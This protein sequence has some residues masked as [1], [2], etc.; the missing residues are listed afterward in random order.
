MKRSWSLRA[1]LSLLLALTLLTGVM[2]ALADGINIIGTVTVTNSSYVN[3]RTGGA[4]TYPVVATVLPGSIYPCIGTAPTGW[5]EILL[6]NGQTGFVSNNLTSFAPGGTGQLPGGQDTGAI[7]KTISVTYRTEAGATLATDYVT[8]LYGV[9]IVPAN[10]GKVPAGYT[11]VSTRRVTVNVDRYG[12]ATPGSVVFT[13]RPYSVP[14]TP[15]PQTAAQV[16]V[17]YRDVYGVTLNTQLVS[18]TPGSRLIRPNAALVP[19]GYTLVGPADVVVSVGT[20]M[21]SMPA[22]VTFIYAQ[23][24]QPTAAPQAAATVPVYYMSSSG[25]YLNVAY[26][27]LNPGIHYISP[28]NALAGA[29]YV[30][31]SPSPAVVNVSAYGVAS[32]NSVS[33]VY[34]PVQ[35]APP[36]S[37]F[38]IPLRYIGI[39]GDP[40][41]TGKVTVYQ[42]YNTIQADNSKVPSGFVLNSSATVQVLVDSNGVANPKEVVFVYRPSSAPP[43]QTPR[44]GVSVS[45]PVYYIGVSGDPLGQDTVTVYQGANSVRAN[46]SKVPSGFVIN[47]ADTVQ[48]AVDAYGTATPASV[49]FV[50]RSASQPP[51]GG[52]ATNPQYLP[53]FVKTRPNPG[54][55]PVYTGPSEG[56][57][58]VGNAT[59]GGGT[60][61]VYGQ[62]NGWALIGYGLSNG[63]YR[64]GFVSMSAI[65]ADITP[66]YL[67][68]THIPQNNVSA[69][70]FVDDP[71]VSTNRELL[72][73]YEGGSPFIFLAYLNDFWAY[74]EIENFEGTGQP[75]RGFVSRRSLGV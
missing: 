52:G 38:D 14:V 35:A 22:S 57:Y 3:V 13:Y 20:N 33:F 4:T 58:R 37:S 50:Y 1:A 16:P 48:V 40:L 11:L 2:P 51:S 75:A 46:H 68:L 71:I 62:E 7:R 19:A 26:L 23:T 53:D 30:L 66:P 67:Q 72:K 64:I 17:Y 61:R 70:L 32:P 45:I 24:V 43:P 36:A 65:P 25:A 41:Y 15:P 54:S 49:T 12:T 39:S 59:L 5:Y 27:T 18:V 34:A 9:N 31:Q 29:G 42:G 60:I 28:D 63:G 56:Y 21:V 44:P 55:Y 73:R 6:D 8:L 10:D 69:S 47:S 74:V